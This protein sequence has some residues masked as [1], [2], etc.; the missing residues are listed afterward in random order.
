MDNNVKPSTIMLIA[1]GVVLFIATLLDWQSSGSVGFNGWETDFY[2][3]HGIIVALIAADVAVTAALRQFTDVNL[4]DQILGF[5]VNQLNLVLGFAAF[6]I[7]FGNIVLESVAIG[8]HLGWI[9][10]AVIV[11]AA[12]M[13]MREGDTADAAPTQF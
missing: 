2:G 6:L 7:T 1:G 5:S 12:I 8:I 11:A 13:D 9:A 4:P 10:S 3:L